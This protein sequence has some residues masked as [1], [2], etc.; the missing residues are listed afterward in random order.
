MRERVNRL[1]YILEKKKN[2]FFS[3]QIHF[4][5]LSSVDE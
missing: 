5:F 4:N 1:M 2:P 3:E